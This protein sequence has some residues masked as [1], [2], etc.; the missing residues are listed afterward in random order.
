MEQMYNENDNMEQE[1]KIAAKMKIITYKMM[2]WNDNK[3]D[4][5]KFGNK[6]ITKMV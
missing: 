2:T 6:I 3:N 4:Y 1:Q 5:A